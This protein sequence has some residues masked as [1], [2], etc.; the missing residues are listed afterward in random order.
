[1]E[2]SVSELPALGANAGRSPSDEF[3]LVLPGDTVVLCV[4]SVGWVRAGA[5]QRA[6]GQALAREEASTGH[7]R[8]VEQLLGLATDASIAPFIAIIDV[9][10]G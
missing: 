2:V 7:R 1:M 5:G 9:L 4:G 6:L 10:G 3:A 8:A